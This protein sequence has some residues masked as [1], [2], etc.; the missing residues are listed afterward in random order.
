MGTGIPCLQDDEQLVELRN[1]KPFL[2]PEFEANHDLALRTWELLLDGEAGNDIWLWADGDEKNI[3]IFY[4]LRSDSPATQPK[5]WSHYDLVPGWRLTSFD[6]HLGISALRRRVERVR[7]GVTEV[8]HMV[9]RRKRVHIVD[10]G[11]RF[12]AIAW[13]IAT[14][15]AMRSANAS[16]G[17]QQPHLHSL[18]YSLT[19]V[20]EFSASARAF[21]KSTISSGYWQ[22][23][24]VCYDRMSSFDFEEPEECSGSRWI[25]VASLVTSSQE[26]NATSF[27]IFCPGNRC[28]G[29]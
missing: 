2:T 9:E 17:D 3:A 15:E 6:L 13:T 29:R 24:G 8:P 11:V 12:A 27:K 10:P 19:K 16:R 4:H 22:I 7:K 1:S 20:V 5:E 25:Y 21:I 26:S 23:H 18:V 14:S 28:A